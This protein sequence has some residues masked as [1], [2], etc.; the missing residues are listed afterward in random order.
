MLRSR[1]GMAATRLVRS[2][3]IRVISG[4]H[5]ISLRL[6]YSDPV[7]KRMRNMQEQRATRRSKTYLGASIGFNQFL[8]T[9]C[10][11]RNLSE[12]GAM[13]Q[14]DNVST[15]P[16]E[17]SL[18]VPVKGKSYRAK[19]VWRQLGRAGLSFV[20]VNEPGRTA[21]TRGQCRL[22]DRERLQAR[23]QAVLEK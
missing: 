6:L 15:M 20:N 21:Q 5:I 17:F 4:F 22:S 13:L 8:P 16:N 19:M 10:I 12:R 2:D 3:R 14:L 9:D 18:T 7:A 11:I 1:P 23:I